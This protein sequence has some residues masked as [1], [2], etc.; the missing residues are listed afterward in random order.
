MKKAVADAPRRGRDNREICVHEDGAHPGDFTSFVFL[1]ILNYAVRVDPEEADS[2]VV[3]GCDSVLDC[4]RDR[5]QR[6]RLSVCL[7]IMGRGL[8]RLILSPDVAECHVELFFRAF[9]DEEPGAYRV[10]AVYDPVW[11]NATFGTR[12]ALVSE[13][14][15]QPLTRDRI[16]LRTVELARNIA[17]P[18][19]STS[20]VIW[21]NDI[22]IK[23]ATAKYPESSAY[24]LWYIFRRLGRHS[25]PGFRPARPGGLSPPH[26]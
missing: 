3:R 14:F 6:E 5:R 12:A 11:E 9:A 2:E 10:C 24:H 15:L 20:V 16:S 18:E 22:I 21:S 1:R 17:I 25:H 26:S 7:K 8:M 4:L 13:A 19:K 23:L